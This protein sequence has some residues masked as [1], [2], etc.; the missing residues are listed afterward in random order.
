VHRDIK[1]RPTKEYVSGYMM[2]YVSLG[3]GDHEQAIS[4][5]QK[6]ADD[7]DCLLS[8]INVWFCFDPLRS[9][10][11]FQALLRRMNFPPPQ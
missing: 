10:P 2:S 3:L 7:R 5:L 1:R 6:A 11:R 8:Y 4:W 9:D